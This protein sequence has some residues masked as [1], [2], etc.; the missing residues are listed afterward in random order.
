[1]WAWML[2]DISCHFS[3]RFRKYVYWSDDAMSREIESFQ[4]LGIAS[5]C[6][7]SFRPG[8]YTCCITKSSSRTC[9]ERIKRSFPYAKRHWSDCTEPAVARQIISVRK[10]TFLNGAL[11][12]T[13]C[14]VKNAVFW[15]SPIDVGKH[16]VMRILKVDRTGALSARKESVAIG[17]EGMD[18]PDGDLV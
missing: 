4:V 16:H 1:M 17:E 6:I 13:K 15:I 18:V 2:V 7:H 11:I 12:F 8:T 14:S 9:S 3:R 10:R 5:W